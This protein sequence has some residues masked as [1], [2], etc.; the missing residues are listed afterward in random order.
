MKYWSNSSHLWGTWARTHSP[1]LMQHAT[2]NALESY[3]N[4][5]KQDLPKNQGLIGI[6]K[7][8]HKLN[9]DLGIQLAKQLAQ[10]KFQGLSGI[11]EFPF[12]SKL[13][14]LLQN[15][16]YDELREAH[17]MTAIDTYEG[18]YEPPDLLNGKCDCDFYYAYLLPC[19]HV[20]C[21]HLI[22]K[23][24]ITE[25]VA[26][27]IIETFGELG[28]EVY[29]VREQYFVPVQEPE[30][31]TG[32][33]KLKLY[34]MCEKLRELYFHVEEKKKQDNARAEAFITRCTEF[35]N[36]MQQFMREEQS[37]S[38]TTE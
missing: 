8:L 22:Y 19:R 37:T 10:N 21:A 1:L 36:E 6:V 34:S 11:K 14:L 3:H 30:D 28:A 24:V 38:G 2:T 12:I 17:K 18:E 32:G 7:H 23:N 26:D 13:P 33:R 9:I 15:R 35:L 16:I 29:H 5:I 27:Q 20:F 31:Y 25:E 4:K